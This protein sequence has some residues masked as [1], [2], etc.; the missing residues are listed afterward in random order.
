MEHLASPVFRLCGMD[1][2]ACKKSVYKGHSNCVSDRGRIMQDLS[3]SDQIAKS[4]S[5]QPLD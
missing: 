4:S 3:R 1:S 2:V 5:H